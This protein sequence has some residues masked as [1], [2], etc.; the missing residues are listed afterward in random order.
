MNE[1]DNTFVRHQSL[2]TSNVISHIVSIHESKSV[3]SIT[4]HVLRQCTLPAVVM[5]Y[6]FTENLGF[7]DLC[8]CVTYICHSLQYQLSGSWELEISHC[9]SNVN[10]IINSH[11]MRYQSRIRQIY[12][13]SPQ[14]GTSILSTSTKIW[15]LHFKALHRFVIVIIYTYTY[16]SCKHKYRGLYKWIMGPN[17]PV[18][19]WPLRKRYICTKVRVSRPMSHWENFNEWIYHIGILVKSLF[20]PIVCRINPFQVQVQ[21]QQFVLFEYI[22]MYWSIVADALQSLAYQIAV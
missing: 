7:K 16:A 11:H 14:I 19:W 18:P 5:I 22:F 17:L 9:S 8:L 10:K 12:R 6:H 15:Y 2:N 21:V 3:Y 13:I 4:R 1:W 20:V